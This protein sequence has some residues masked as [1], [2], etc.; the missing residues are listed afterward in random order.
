[1]LTLFCQA[2]YYI[3][4]PPSSGFLKRHIRILSNDMYNFDEGDFGLF[5][6]PGPG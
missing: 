5:A 3:R 4:K 6:F 1:M 2:F